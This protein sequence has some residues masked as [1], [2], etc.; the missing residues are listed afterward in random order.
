L[1][2]QISKLEICP[3]QFVACLFHAQILHEGAMPFK[4]NQHIE[5]E[6]SSPFQ[7]KFSERLF[8]SDKNDA[9]AE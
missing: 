6:R 1:P 4:A 7:S 3:D 8:P 9:E 5:A 2:Q